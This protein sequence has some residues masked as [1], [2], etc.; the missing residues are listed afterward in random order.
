[1]SYE[2]TIVDPSIAIDNAAIIIPRIPLLFINVFLVD[3]IIKVSG[4]N[5]I[6]KNS[7]FCY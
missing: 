7:E 3:I 6:L 4:K 2:T 1:M 5:H